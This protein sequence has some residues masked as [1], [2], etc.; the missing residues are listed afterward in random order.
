MISNR[1]KYINLLIVS[2]LITFHANAQDAEAVFNQAENEFA[3]GNYQEAEQLYTQVLSLD[4]ENMNAYLRRGF[5]RSVLK[6]YQLAVE[7]YSVVIDKHPEHPF[8]YL[9]RGSAFNKLEDW[10]AALA[11]F[12]RVLSL[13]PKNQEAYNNRGWAK[14]GKGLYKEACQDWKTSRKLGNEE[15]KIILKNNSCK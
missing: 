7:D 1:S 11:D 15:A 4:S 8:A 5:S 6:D 13:D 14:H 9:S 3:V 2:L 12:N 10:D